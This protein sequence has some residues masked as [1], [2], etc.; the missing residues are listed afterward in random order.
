MKYSPAGGKIVMTVVSHEDRVQVAVRDHGIR[1]AASIRPALF[2][3]FARA[4][5]VRGH[6]MPGLGLGLYLCKAI[7]DLHG[8]SIEVKSAVG[9]GSTFTLIL[10]RFRLR[11][12]TSRCP[13]AFKACAARCAL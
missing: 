10:L 5:Q 9:A 6:P 2:Q 8:G 1:I 4:P 7:M 11:Q 12:P 3:R 13:K